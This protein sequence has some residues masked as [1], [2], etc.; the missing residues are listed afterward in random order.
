VSFNINLIFWKLWLI[1]ILKKTKDAIFQTH[2]CQHSVVIFVNRSR[3]FKQG[4]F[5]SLERVFFNINLIFWKLWLILTLKKTKDAIFQNN[6]CQHSVV[7]YVNHSKKF[8]QGLFWSLERVFF[9]IN[10]VFGS[11]DWF[12]SWRRRRTPFFKTIFVNIL[13]LSMLVAAEN[14]N[15]AC[16]EV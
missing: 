2:F 9:N 12:W 5:W 3:K 14:S 8:K 13:W 11:Y 4:L 10:L 16:F 7:T 6:F 15:R 1:L